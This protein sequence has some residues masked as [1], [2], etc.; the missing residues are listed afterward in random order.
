L[1]LKEPE[2]KRE[3]EQTDKRGDEMIRNNFF[4]PR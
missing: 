2:V 1:E 4:A 3:E